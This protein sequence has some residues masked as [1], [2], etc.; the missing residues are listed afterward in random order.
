MSKVSI[1]VPVY[2]T[3]QYLGRCL[4]S[5]IS[6]SF[7]DIEILTINDGSPDNSKEI[8]LKYADLDPRIRYI[9]KENGGYGSV[10]ELGIKEASAEFFMVC[11]SDDY[12]SA[13]CVE[14]LYKQATESDLDIVVGAKYIVYQGSDD[15]EYNDSKITGI[16]PEIKAGTVYTDTAPFFFLEPSP[17]AKIFRKTLAEKISF[18]RKV[19]Y[20]DYLLYSL[21]LER[22]HRVMYLSE[23]LAYY[24]V[25]RPGNSTT[26][27][28]EKVFND[29]YI[30]LKSVFEQMTL[31]VMYARQYIHFRYILSLLKNSSRKTKEKYF[32]K[33]SEL[34]SLLSKN[35]TAIIK[36][37]PLKSFTTK[38]K[39][40]ILLFGPTGKLVLKKLI[41]Y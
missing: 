15:E 31:P 36:E 27:Q 30:V 29:Y 14:R 26:D 32:E 25:D 7:T 13:Q 8:L 11:D 1:I 39:L 6:Q 23:P 28:N 18:P 20:T 19:S 12:L 37:Y 17:H 35:K 22:S 41:D 3:A 10:L 34:L 5:L 9:E 4:D 24:C 2:N 21:C 38:T 40:H 16:C 33:Y